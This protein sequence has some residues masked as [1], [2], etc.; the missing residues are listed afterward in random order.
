MHVCRVTLADPSTHD[1]LQGLK[2]ETEEDGSQY[3]GLF[4]AYNAARAILRHSEILKALIETMKSAQDL[5]KNIRDVID[6]GFRIY[7]CN[8]EDDKVCAYHMIDQPDVVLENIF[9]PLKEVELLPT[10]RNQTEWNNTLKQQ[11]IFT[12]WYLVHEMSHAIATILAADH[13]IADRSTPSNCCAYGLAEYVDIFLGSDNKEYLS[14]ERGFYMES[15]L[16]GIMKA[17]KVSETDWSIDYLILEIAGDP[18]LVSDDE[19]VYIYLWM[20]L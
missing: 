11:I 14:G 9:L 1:D 19:S 20:M 3:P 2:K 17:K 13:V 15:Q 16:G 4:K 12:T 7:V 10:S 5:A 18:H 8:W 6:R